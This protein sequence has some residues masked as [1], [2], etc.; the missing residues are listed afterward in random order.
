MLMYLILFALVFETNGWNCLNENLL[1]DFMI[2]NGWNYVTVIS[3]YRQYCFLNDSRNKDVFIRSIRVTSLDNVDD[4]EDKVV[5]LCDQVK[6][7]NGYLEFVTQRRVQTVFIWIRQ[8]E[9]DKLGPDFLT[10]LQANAYF[11][12]VYFKE[13]DA[14]LQVKSVINTI[15]FQRP[16]VTE[17]D[18]KEDLVLR[19]T[20]DLQ[21]Q[22]ITGISLHFEPYL[23]AKPNCNLTKK[24]LCP[25]TGFYIDLETQLS[26]MLNFTFTNEFEPNGNWG[27]MPVT[28]TFENGTFEG[29]VGHVVNNTHDISLSTWVWTDER[30]NILDFAPVLHTKLILALTPHSKKVN[31]YT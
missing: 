5:I 31:I 14:K 18:I 6:D 4:I 22:P 26:V 17:I 3:E 23:I 1:M 7:A 24:H 28:G 8:F 20:F 11:Y 16:I 21:G 13:G 15:R 25:Q 30:K 29:V 2:S 10:N 12:L 27:L 19:E 9:I